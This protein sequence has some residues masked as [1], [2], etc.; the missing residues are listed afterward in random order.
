[1]GKRQT[2][3]LRK[4]IVQHAQELLQRPVVQVVLRNRVVLHGS[5]KQVTAEQLVMQDQ[6]EGRHVMPLPQIEEIIYD[7]ETAY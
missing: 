2:R 1:M 4:D 7:R 3:I 5:L 6:R